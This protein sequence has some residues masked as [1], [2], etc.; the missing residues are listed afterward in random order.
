[1]DDLSVQEKGGRA[2]SY[3][4]KFSENSRGRWASSYCGGIE[5]VGGVG[6]R[7]KNGEAPGRLG[8]LIL[9]YLQGVLL[10]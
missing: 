4:V 9:R 6:W 7:G 10:K 5:K 8:S 2:G 1:M 3:G